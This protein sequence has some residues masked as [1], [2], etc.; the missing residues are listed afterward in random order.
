MTLRAGAT[1]P[2]ASE[3]RQFAAQ[4]LSRQMVP[5]EIHVVAD[6]VRTGVGKIDRDRLRWQAESGT[7]AV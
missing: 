3:L 2:V 6:L 1:L 7:T 4:R 5:E